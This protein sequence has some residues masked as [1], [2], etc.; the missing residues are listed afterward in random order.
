MNRS[1][2]LTILA[3]ASGWIALAALLLPD[4][5]MPRILIAAAF[6]TCGPGAAALRPARTVLRRHG[7]ALAGLEAAVVVVAVSVSVGALVAEAFLLT[8]SFT[9][10]RCTVALAVLTTITA[11][12][13]VRTRG[14][15]PAGSGSRSSTSP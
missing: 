10:V 5:S 8:H 1:V 4:A 13:P 14:P 15:S 3:A 2:A 9:A 11:L 12:W 6:I 7:Q